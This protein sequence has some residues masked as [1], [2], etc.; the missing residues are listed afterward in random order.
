[1]KVHRK[2][3]LIY[4]IAATLSLLVSVGLVLYALRQNI[5]LYLTPTQIAK[6]QVPQHHL[7]RIGGMVKKGSVKRERNRLGV[8]FILT[9]FKHTTEVIFRGVLPALFREGQGV[10]AE[11]RMN[12]GGVFVAQNVLAKHDEKYM[13]PGI[14]AK[15]AYHLE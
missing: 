1:M 15:E 2:R 13:P 11:G 8:R 6:G 10:V 4:I 7:F 9:D 14:H 5:Q 12:K 3:R